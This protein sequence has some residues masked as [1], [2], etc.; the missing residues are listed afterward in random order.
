MDNK[1]RLEVP[2]PKA[3][4]DPNQVRKPARPIYLYSTLTFNLSL[5]TFF[6]QF[7]AL[8]ERASLALSLDG[9]PQLAT[10]I[11]QFH[12]FSNVQDFSKL[13]DDVLSNLNAKGRSSAVPR[14][15]GNARRLL[16]SRNSALGN[17]TALY[18]RSNPLHITRGKDAQL[19]DEE[20]TRYLD[21]VNNVSHVGHSN[22]WVS[23][24]DLP[25]VLWL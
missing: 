13:V 17:C 4:W 21:C 6:A 1:P 8:R 2:A 12:W 16:E 5:Q 22:E 24:S 18:N 7:V 23:K 14:E 20:G 10:Q 9:S 19:Y 11:S 15:S 3:S 25:P